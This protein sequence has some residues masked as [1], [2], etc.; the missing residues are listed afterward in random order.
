MIVLMAFTA[1]AIDIGQRNQQLAA[2]QHS[3]DAAVLA[4]AQYLSVHDS[5]YAGAA[6]RVKAVIEQNLGIEASAW[7]GCR[8]A[9]HLDVLALGD[10]ECISFRR[11]AATAT[12]QVKNDIR[13]RLP[14]FTMRT[15]F[16]SALGI[17]T[18]DLAAA[19]A[20]NGNNCG[21]TGTQSCVPGTTAPTTTEPPVT[22]TTTLEQ[23]CDVYTPVE[24]AFYTSVW[25][26]CA[27]VRSEVDVEYFRTEVCDHDVVEFDFKGFHY[28]WTLDGRYR[29][30]WW[31]SVCKDYVSDGPREKW[32]S[33]VCFEEPTTLVWTDWWLWSEC[34]TRRPSLEDWDKHYATTTTEPPKATTTTAP[35]VTPTS[36]PSSIDLSN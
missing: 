13:V 8:D 23:Y 35:P 24:L 36:V 31:W 21:P 34:S 2:A 10:T 17:D 22:T 3:I 25:D 33:T 1:V 7:D 15:I 6:A 29:Y 18:I 16:G 19:A 5:D 12:S 28:T 32:F 26:T 14:A 11:I 9:D 4:A 27:K 30:L 20:S